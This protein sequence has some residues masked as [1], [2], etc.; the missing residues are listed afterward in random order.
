[1]L[2]FLLCLDIKK[3]EIHLYIVV[4]WMIIPYN[5]HFPT[6]T[7]LYHFFVI[8]VMLDFE[9]LLYDLKICIIP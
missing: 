5:Y 8:F 6:Q 3:I 9:K 7:K 4:S 1:M 2:W